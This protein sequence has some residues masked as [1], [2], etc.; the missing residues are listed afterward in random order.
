MMR[1]RFATAL[2]VWLLLGVGAALGQAA[3]AAQAAP[4][5]QPAAAKLEFDV[6]SVRPSAPLDMAKL[7]AQMAAG[8]MPRMGAHVEGLLAE[9]NYLS[10]KDL[11]AAAYKVK[12]YQITGPDWMGTQRFDISARMPEGSAK[13]DAPKML[14]ALLADRFKVWSIARRRSTRC[15]RWWRARADRS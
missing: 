2:G 10:L 8:H 11:I 3:A 9:Y 4:S 13:D 12:D 14:Q 15:W 1:N 6:A 7:Q 5:A